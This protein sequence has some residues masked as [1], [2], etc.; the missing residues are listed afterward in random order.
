MPVALFGY[1]IFPG[2]PQTTKSKLLTAEEKRLALERLPEPDIARGNLDWSLLRRLVSSWEFYLLPLL[3][4]LAGDTE[5]YADNSILALWLKSLGTYSVQQ[6]NYIP[7]AVYGLAIV[8]IL[9]CSWYA[10]YFKRSWGQ[11]QVGIF[12][13]ITA[14]ISGAIMLKPPTYA[15]KFFALYLNGIE[16]GFRAVLFAWANEIM[17]MDDGKRA[18]IIGLMNAMSKFETSPNTRPGD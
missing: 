12:L 13:A 6:I 1:M 3:A 9:V 10:D 2:H 7:T 18:V 14:I 15:S 4:A 17:R 11:V 5:M 8:S 16:L